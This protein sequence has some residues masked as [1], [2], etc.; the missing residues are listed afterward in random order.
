[1]KK[2]L[3][4]PQI[5]HYNWLLR[6]HGL[7]SSLSNSYDERTYELLDE[8]FSLLNG[9]APVSENGAR[10]LWFTSER[11]PIEKYGNYEERLA[12]G[13]VS[14]YEEFEALW[15]EEFPD[16]ISWYNF[17]AVE[18]KE[19]GY[20][21]IFFHHRLVIEQDARKEKGY[22]HDISEFT[23][24]LVD[25]V[26]KC[27][28][29]LE[30]GRYNERIEKELPPQHRT[31]IIK[32]RDFWDIFPDRRESF[33]ENT[34]QEE[35]KEFLRYID[36]QRTDPDWQ[37]YR[38]PT[39]TANEFFQYCALGYRANNYSGKELDPKAQYRKHA[40]GRDEG[41]TDINPESPEEF[42][43]WLK[44]PNRFGG[45]PFEICRGGNSTHIS[46]YVL[47]DEKGFSLC[48]AGSA[49]TRTVET[50]KF[51]VALRQAGAPV[52]LRE[53]E[54]LA[55]RVTEMEEIGIVPEGIIPAYCHSMFPGRTIID[56]MNLPDEDR[57][58]VAAKAQW[59][60]QPKAALQE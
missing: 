53:A 27:I 59:F 47:H 50:L 45:H 31:G 30:S 15:K 51:F 49:W 57:E 28:D 9:V 58:L 39:M 16:E 12:D 38:K 8:L 19:I 46:L 18:D 23:E 36:E 22:T 48:L 43:H 1:M 25:S 29:E 24:W 10:E 44:N 34:T 4:T 56:F 52:Y 5:E 60:P 2:T 6:S 14:S 41:L 32:R 20:R 26:R 42:L 17:A 33:F 11:G 54:L 55:D 37:H 21:A 7:S 3:Y 13:D 35:L 40:D